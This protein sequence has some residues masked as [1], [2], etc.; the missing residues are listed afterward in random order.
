M[1]DGSIFLFL[2]YLLAGGSHV[3]STDSSG[4]A[5]ERDCVVFSVCEFIL[6][7]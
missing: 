4:V 6:C 2:K 1:V 7:R 3:P 5:S